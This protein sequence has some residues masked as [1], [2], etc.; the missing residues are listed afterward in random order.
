MCLGER[1]FLARFSKFRYGFT[2]TIYI[3]PCSIIPNLWIRVYWAGF[4][5]ILTF[6]GF[7]PTQSH[8]IH[9]D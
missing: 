8:S 3:R 9:M 1:M 2:H 4:R 7:K 5:Y 6:Y